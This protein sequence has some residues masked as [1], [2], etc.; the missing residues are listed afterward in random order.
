KEERKRL[1]IQSQ[2]VALTKR[3]LFYKRR[4]P[5]EGVEIGL[6]LDWNSR[7]SGFG[8]GIRMELPKEW[9]WNWNGTSEG[10][11]LELKWNS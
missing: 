11:E 5:P 3:F 2:L 10:V 9:N 4:N 7:R 8:V 6:E 1:L